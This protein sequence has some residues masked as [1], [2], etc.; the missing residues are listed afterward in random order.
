MRITGTGR[1]IYYNIMHPWVTTRGSG[2]NAKLCS[3]NNLTRN[4]CNYV[5]RIVQNGDFFFFSYIY[6]RDQ[7]RCSRGYGMFVM[8]SRRIV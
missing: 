7:G 4:W 2:D 5:A 3:S 8:T 6:R 1:C